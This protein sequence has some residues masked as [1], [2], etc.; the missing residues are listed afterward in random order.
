MPGLF[1]FILK[2]MQPLSVHRV[3]LR[4]ALVLTSAFAWLMFFQYFLYTRGNIDFAVAQ[5]AFLYALS[6]LTTLLL[7]PLAARELRHGAQRPLLYAL[8]AVVTS[9]VTAG[10]L[11][12]GVWPDIAIRVG[13]VCFALTLGM[14]RALYWVPYQMEA[15]ETGRAGFST[16]REVLIA[17]APALAGWI[18]A[19]YPLGAAWLFFF[20][21][22][23]AAL[24]FI[25]FIY[26]RDVPE[27]FSWDFRE[28]FDRL[29]LLE[30][31][32]LVSRAFW[33]GVAGT[34]LLL[35]W[36]MIIFLLVWRSFAVVGALLS[37]TFLV[38]LLSRAPLR[39]FLERSASKDS[40]YLAMLLAASPW[41]FKF[42]ASGAFSVV[43]IDTYSRATA[44]NRHGIDSLAFEQSADGGSLVDE[45]TALKE[46]ALQGGRL[47]CAALGAALAL[48]IATPA[49]IAVVFSLAAVSAAA[50][51]WSEAR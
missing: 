13:V 14:Y 17:L 46:I 24:S 18:I 15:A 16:R 39:R 31:R 50:L 41:V 12:S 2:R 44:P 6:S 38:S 49:A 1:S 47:A 30:N 11:F 32:T 21:A 20:A 48:L 40:R 5:T 34:A 22:A 19:A 42:V 45:Y 29:F 36:P 28:T 7:T 43:L 35:F 51:A 33:D 37:L 4:S 26:V 8:L 27:D 3:M 10:A 9:L 23:L 25:P